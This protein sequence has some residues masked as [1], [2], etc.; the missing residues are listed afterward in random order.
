MVCPSRNLKFA[1]DVEQVSEILGVAS[2]VIVRVPS[3]IGQFFG[4]ERHS[5]EELV[6]N[7]ATEFDSVEPIVRTVDGNC[8]ESTGLKA[9]KCANSIARTSILLEAVA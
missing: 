9:E 6:A 3:L 2:Q 1:I 5:V 7:A 4:V 8:F